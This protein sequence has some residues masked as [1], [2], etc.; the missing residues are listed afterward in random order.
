MRRVGTAGFTV[1]EVVLV[2]VI[3]LIL[4]AIIVPNFVNYVAKSGAQ[5]TKANLQILRSSIETFRSENNGA[6]PPRIE[7]LVPL[8]L[9]AVP[10]DGVKNKARE[11]DGRADGTGGWIYDPAVGS[12]KPNLTGVDAYGENYCNY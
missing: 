6:N 3:I 9:P 10:K 1:V 7:N 4:S 2:I 12:V 5:T 11:L 8:Y